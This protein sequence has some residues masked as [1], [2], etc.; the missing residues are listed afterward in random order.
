[1]IV[2]DTTVLVYAV[3]AEH[4]LRDP[5]RDAVAL[6]RDGDLRATTTVEVIQEFAHVRSKRRTRQDAAALARAYAA[7]LG[8]LLV[9]E[10]DDLYD[11]LSR[12]RRS[13]SLGAFDAVL[14]AAAVRKG[15]GLASTDRAFR[16]VRDLVHFD[17]ASPTFLEDL[18]K[19]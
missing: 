5:C 18:L 7:G 9:V 1:M 2:F 17:P 3:G 8:P 14:A 12:F 11:G 13:K 19:A 4:P 6:V 15:W 10:E 16:H